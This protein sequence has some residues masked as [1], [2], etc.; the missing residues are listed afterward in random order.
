MNLEQPW[1]S[2]RTVH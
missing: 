2:M 1:S